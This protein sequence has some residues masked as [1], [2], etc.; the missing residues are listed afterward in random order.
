MYK[1]VSALRKILRSVQYLIFQNNLSYHV[2][3]VKNLIRQRNYGR[4]V[5]ACNTGL[6]K[7]P[8]CEE[9]EELKLK[10]TGQLYKKIYNEEYD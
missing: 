5:I 6:K 7:F 8:N 2:N 3:R 4:A 9:L 1:I 10:A